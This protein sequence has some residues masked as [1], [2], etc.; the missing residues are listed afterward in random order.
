MEDLN[1]AKPDHWQKYYRGEDAEQRIKRHFSYSDRIRYYWPQPEAARAVGQLLALL[2]ETKIRAPLV[3]QY[4]TA[5][6]PGV[7]DGSVPAT[8][9]ALLST[10]VRVVIGKYVAATL[11]HGLGRIPE[12]A[13]P[14][15]IRW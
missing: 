11:K 8:A 13:E 7:A 9:R 10:A 5:A 14:S 1:C 15:R 12:L 3:R 4:L 6:Y 2:G